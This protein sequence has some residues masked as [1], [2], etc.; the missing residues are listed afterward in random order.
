[1]KQE[2]TAMIP[3]EEYLELKNFRDEMMK[4]NKVAF[5][6]GIGYVDAYT[7]MRTNSQSVFLTEKEAILEIQRYNNEL[8][9]QYEDL[10][11]RYDELKTQI[12]AQTKAQAQ[13]K[14]QVQTPPEKP[15]N[16]FSRLFKK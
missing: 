9:E 11:K 3:M 14:T 16:I 2:S 10:R 6:T 7:R 4:N 8:I 15:K 1:M 13:T 12:Q 5:Y